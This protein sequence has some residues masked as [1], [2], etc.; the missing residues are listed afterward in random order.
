MLRFLPLLGCSLMMLVCVGPML[1]RR[2]RRDAQPVAPQD[3]I[4][5][6]RDEVAALRRRVSGQPADPRVDQL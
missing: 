4:A 3:E 2:N 1:F 6:L 5:E